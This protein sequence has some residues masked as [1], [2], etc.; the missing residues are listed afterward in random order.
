MDYRLRW[1]GTFYR[2]KYKYFASNYFITFSEDPVAAEA[3]A[4]EEIE[5]AGAKAGNNKPIFKCC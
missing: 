1:L 4:L 2:K 3:K 5:V